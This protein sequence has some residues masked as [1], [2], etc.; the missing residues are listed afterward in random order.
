MEKIC[1]AESEESR[2]EIFEYVW[3][4]S[5]NKVFVESMIDCVTPAE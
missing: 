5:E 1:G 3:S 2:N 4:L